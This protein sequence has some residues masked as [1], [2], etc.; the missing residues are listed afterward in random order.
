MAALVRRPRSLQRVPRRRAGD[1]GELHEEDAKPQKDDDVRPGGEARG[2]TGE[3]QTRGTSRTHTRSSL[4]TPTIQVDTSK[5]R[6]PQSPR[7]V[8]G[9]KA[10]TK[11]YL[12]KTKPSRIGRLVPPR[13]K[14]GQTEC[15]KLPGAKGEPRGHERSEPK[16]PSR[17]TSEF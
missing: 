16:G 7:G 15:K 2:D 5:M 10:L 17:P 13:M 1:S 9:R 6:N 12:G 4:D 11:L 14:I 3:G 8:R